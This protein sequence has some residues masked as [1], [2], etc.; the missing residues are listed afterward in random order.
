M[1]LIS[2]EKLGQG[3]TLLTVMTI[4]AVMRKVTF[5]NPAG[6]GGAAGVE[7]TNST[8]T[9]VGLI[10]QETVAPGQIGVGPYTSVG[11]GKHCEK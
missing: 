6:V 3:A 1:K 4:G 8:S 7:L 11:T 9:A 2:N 10:L 5:I